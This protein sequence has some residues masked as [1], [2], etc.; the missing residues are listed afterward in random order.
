MES[1]SCIRDGPQSQSPAGENAQQ[2]GAVAVSTLYVEPLPNQGLFQ[3]VY[4][5][6]G[7]LYSPITLEWLTGHFEMRD[8]QSLPRNALYTA[9]QEFCHE[10]DVDAVNS[11]SFGKIIRQAFP[12]IRTRR[13]G[14]R[15]QS[16]YH[17]YGIGIKENSPYKVYFNDL[18]PAQYTE[19]FRKSLGIEEAPCKRPASPPCSSD[20]SLVADHLRIRLEN[21][22]SFSFLPDLP[23]AYQVVLPPTVPVDKVQSFFVMY[24]AHSQA[25]VDI[26]LKAAFSKIESHVKQFWRGIAPYTLCA[27]ATQPLISIITLFDWKLYKNLVGVLIPNSMEPILPSFIH[28]IRHFAKH[29]VAWLEESMTTIP[30]ILSQSK[31]KA[32]RMFAGSL[33]RQ[34]AMAHLFQASKIHFDSSANVRQMVADWHSLDL[35]SINRQTQWT[36]SERETRCIARAQRDFE[37]LI[38]TGA[39]HSSSL[40]S[41]VDW[42][43]GLMD[44]SILRPVTTG[45]IAFDVAARLFFLKWTYI[46][47]KIIRDLTLKSAPSFGFFHLVQTLLNEYVLYLLESHTH[48]RAEK[49]MSEKTNACIKTDAAYTVQVEFLA[50][51]DLPLS[52]ASPPKPTLFSNATNTVHDDHNYCSPTTAQSNGRDAWE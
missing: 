32:A 42:I 52:S 23:S 44:E 4:L 41:L 19:P 24:R 27:I 29:F 39:G 8:G 45:E 33:K 35:T 16:K 38:R 22:E 1:G 40:V 15:G 51:A 10:A 49:E 21:K 3:G 31:L 30:V 7:K 5:V 14:T 13:L 47:S 37:T 43:S 9:Y 28:A 2:S 18:K 12:T 48:D 6:H 25:L 26:I 50:Q 34:T 46:S 17:Y 36:F 20:C 11:A